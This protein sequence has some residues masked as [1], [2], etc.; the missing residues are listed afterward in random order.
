MDQP[1]FLVSGCMK[2]VLY[3]S[4][5]QEI[6]HC[7]ENNHLV[8]RSC[9]DHHNAC[10]TLQAE[11]GFIIKK[12]TQRRHYERYNTPQGHH[13]DLEPLSDVAS[14]W[15]FLDAICSLQGV[16][17]SYYSSSNMWLPFTG[18]DLLATVYLQW[19]TCDANFHSKEIII[20]SSHMSYHWKACENPSVMVKTV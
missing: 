14:K 16:A 18:N 19:F 17:G 8:Q 5:W 15:A 13:T 1:L 20:A 9:K 4:H 7:W 2:K 3:A 11:Q 10:I 6:P 12:K